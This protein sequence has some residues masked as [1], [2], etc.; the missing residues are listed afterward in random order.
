[1]MG[2]RSSA[3]MQVMNLRD[4]LFNGGIGPRLIRRLAGSHHLFTSRYNRSAEE[5]LRLNSLLGNAH[6]RSARTYLANV[7]VKLH[8]LSNDTGTMRFPK[9]T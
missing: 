3:C 6:L 2:A 8:A 5:M 4:L 7:L 9:D 1:M